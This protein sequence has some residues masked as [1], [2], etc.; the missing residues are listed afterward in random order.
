M[1]TKEEKFARIN[2][3]RIARAVHQMELVLASAKSMRVHEIDVAK[4]AKPLDAPYKD[5]RD[6]LAVEILA[7]PN[8]DLTPAGEKVAE[9]VTE[10]LQEAAPAI[11]RAG[12]PYEDL[13]TTQLIDKMI[14]LGAILATRRQ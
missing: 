11:S 8:G 10:N 6:P 2:A 3:P 1:T 14:A 13:P 4:L 12:V 5:L 9:A 7:E